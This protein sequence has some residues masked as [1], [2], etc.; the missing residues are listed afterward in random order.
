MLGERR[1]AAAGPGEEPGFFDLVERLF[2]DLGALVDQKLTLLTIELKQEAALVV[3]HLLVLLVGA[4]LALVG[5]LQLSTAA[6]V[7]IGRATGSVPAGYGSVGLVL[8]AVGGALLAMTRGRLEKRTLLPR[9]TLDEFRRD[10]KWIK[11]EF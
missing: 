7:W 9:K 4:A 3:R 10:A 11:D 1:R 5:L 6:A 2:S 8:V